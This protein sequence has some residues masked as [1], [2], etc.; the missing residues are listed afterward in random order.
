MPREA[1]PAAPGGCFLA[2][3]WTADFFVQ[4]NNTGGPVDVWAVEGVDEVLLLI[5][6]E[7][8]QYL[9]EA[10]SAERLSL[11][12]RDIGPASGPCDTGS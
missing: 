12:R 4:L 9:P 10:I 11:V 7:G 5:S 8:Y 1:S 6:P 3:E 2:D